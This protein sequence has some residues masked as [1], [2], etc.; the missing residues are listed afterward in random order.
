MKQSQLASPTKNR[1][2][3]HLACNIWFRTQ[4]RF[5]KSRRD[6]NDSKTSDAS[7]YKYETHQPRLLKVPRLCHL[8]PLAVFLDTLYILQ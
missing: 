7:I 1:L 5:G 4:L 8:L 3:K 2:S 6:V